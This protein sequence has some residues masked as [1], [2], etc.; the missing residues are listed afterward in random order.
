MNPF[1]RG[2]TSGRNGQGRFFFDFVCYSYVMVRSEVHS[3]I[4]FIYVVFV[5]C[6]V[7]CVPFIDKLLL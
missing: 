2:F 1:S 7:G 6:F 4:V 3:L 5:Y